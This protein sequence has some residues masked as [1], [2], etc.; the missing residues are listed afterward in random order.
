MA[1]YEN[2]GQYLL[3][4]PSQAYNLEYYKEAIREARNLC[5]QFGLTKIVAD[6]RERNENF[7]VIDR[8]DLGVEMAQI[9]GNKIQLAIV[10]HSDVIDKLGENAAVNRGGRVFATDSLEKALKWLGVE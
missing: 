7:P 3:M 5:E 4:K 9:L 6:V 1:T 2:K 8:F 10:A